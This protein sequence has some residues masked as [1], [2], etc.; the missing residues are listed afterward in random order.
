MLCKQAISEPPP[1]RAIPLPPP[2]QTKTTHQEKQSNFTNP[3]KTSQSYISKQSNTGWTIL[4]LD[5]PI[6]IFTTNWAKN[7][8]HP[9]MCIWS[10]FFC[11]SSSWKHLISYWKCNFPLTSLVRLFVGQLVGRSF[12]C[13]VDRL[14]GW[15]VCLSKLLQSY[16]SMILSEHIIFNCIATLNSFIQNNL[17]SGK[18][19]NQ[20]IVRSAV[21]YYESTKFFFANRKEGKDAK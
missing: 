19:V 8:E 16:S 4:L 3:D 10:A 15:S 1:N 11:N 9:L 6:Y 2:R 14:V 20:D 21:T 7:L 18:C 12:G 13:L 5:G 17:P